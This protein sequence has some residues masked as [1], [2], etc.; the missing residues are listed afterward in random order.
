MFSS[1]PGFRRFVQFEE[2][3]QPVLQA[4]E[5]I[6]FTLRDVEFAFNPSHVEGTVTL[7]VTTAR[8]IV[9]FQGKD[10]AYDFDPQYVI[11]H[12]IT[13]DPSGYNKPCLYCQ[14]NNFDD[15]EESEDEEDSDADESNGSRAEGGTRKAKKSAVDYSLNPKEMYLAPAQES[16]LKGLFGSAVLRKFFSMMR[17]YRS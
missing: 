6:D 8:I 3:G 14:L 1:A 5:S 13:R 15:F 17:G 10:V 12:A 2:S 16:D 7:Y 9:S 4:T 11:L